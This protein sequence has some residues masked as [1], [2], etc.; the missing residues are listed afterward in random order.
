MKKRKIKKGRIALIIIAV[1]FIALSGFAG[2]KVALLVAGW[3]NM[4]GEKIDETDE[5]LQ[6]T[7]FNV[8]LVGIDRVSESTDVMMLVNVDTEA[9]QVNI[10]SIYRDTRVTYNGGAHKLN[11]VYKYYKKDIG[12]TVSAIKEI[13]GAP[14]HY[15]MMVDLEGFVKIIDELGGVDFYV[16]QDMKYKDEFQDLYIDLKEG[17]QHL[18]GEH[19][20]QLV[21]FRQYPLGDVARA[22][23]QQDFMTAL[24]K[25]H[26]NLGTVTKIPELF[27][28]MS[29]YITTDVTMGLVTS[30]LKLMTK[31]ADCT[32]ERYEMPGEGAYVG[33]VSYFLQFEDEIYDMYREYFMGTGEPAVKAYTD[34]RAFGWPEGWKHSK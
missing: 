23:V 24:I 30:N 33:T 15:Y 14:I 34:Y 27:Y 10:S 6:D 7:Q 12:A 4:S 13:T 16:P 29:D 2:Y 20:M 11:S 5:V 25:Q 1:F 9:M 3:N 8:L 19:A 28:K 21:R 26:L 17:M 31:M 18:D 32:I 22:Q